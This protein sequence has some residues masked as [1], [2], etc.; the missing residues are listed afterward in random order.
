MQPTIMLHCLLVGPFVGIS[1]QIARLDPN[2]A[3]NETLLSL[4]DV[5][6]AHI[7]NGNIRLSVF[8][9]PAV[10]CISLSMKV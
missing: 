9:W 8:T 7:G 1:L 2:Q 5:P 6:N 10:E 3:T 4:Y